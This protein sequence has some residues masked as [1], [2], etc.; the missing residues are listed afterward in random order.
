MLYL[1]VIVKPTASVI[2]VLRVISDLFLGIHELLERDL[3]K[4]LLRIAVKIRSALIAV[5]S[6]IN[7]PVMLGIL[8]S[9]P[10]HLPKRR[11]DGLS[12]NITGTLT[13]GLDVLLHDHDSRLASDD[14]LEH[15][16]SFT[17]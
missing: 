14:L 12:T 4:L 17:I 9:V 1:W 5:L 13:L 7:T 16:C 3:A 10:I 8:K 6:N 11:G 2:I 15:D